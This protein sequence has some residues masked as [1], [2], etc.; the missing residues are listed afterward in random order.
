MSTVSIQQ[1]TQ[2]ITTW[3]GV[4]ENGEP[5]V[6]TEQG[7]VIAQLTPPTQSDRVVVQPRKTMDQWLDEQ[8]QRRQGVFGERMITDSV[9]VI[10]ELRG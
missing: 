3:L 7:R 10:D 2:D 6:I 9:A 5:V 4:V 1:F 8:K